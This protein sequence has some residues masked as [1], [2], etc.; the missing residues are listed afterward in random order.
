M[1]INIGIFIYANN[2][3]ILVKNM[4]LS[5]RKELLESA[6]EVLYKLRKSLREANYSDEELGSMID[7]FAELSDQIDV[8]EASLKE[9]KTKYSELNK[10]LIPIME[11]I[12]SLGQNSMQTKRFLLTIKRAAY[13][14]T[15]LKY[16]EAFELSLTKVNSKLKQI[17][18]DCLEATKTVSSVSA[19]IGVQKIGEGSLF[20]NILDKLKSIFNTLVGKIKSVNSDVKDL[21]SIAKKMIK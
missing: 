2:F 9:L 7:E 19:S 15:N 3:K 20:K 16:K 14:K 8:A 13:E 12:K 4:K 10:E 6:D 17:L 1:L 5:S 11:N 18:T 21:Q